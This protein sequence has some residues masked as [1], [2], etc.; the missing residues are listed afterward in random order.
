MNNSQEQSSGNE[1]VVRDFWNGIASLVTS[2][3]EREKLIS[4]VKGT[5]LN[6]LINLLLEVLKSQ[7]Q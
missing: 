3:E 1:L 2:L 5:C 4:K 6:P 7:A